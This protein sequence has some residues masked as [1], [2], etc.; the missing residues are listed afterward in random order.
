VSPLGNK[1]PRLG[2]PSAVLGKWGKQKC[3]DF[4]TGRKENRG[5]QSLWLLF[6]M[7]TDPVQQFASVVRMR[8]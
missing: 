5:S 3:A 4:F 2:A 8:L 1:Y 7:L 6:S